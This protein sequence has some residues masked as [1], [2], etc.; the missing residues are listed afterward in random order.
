MDW[1]RREWRN[2]ADKTNIFQRLVSNRRRGRLK[3]LEREGRTKIEY[4]QK[5]SKS[6][7]QDR[8]K[9][10]FSKQARTYKGL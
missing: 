3:P 8:M 6:E 2:I 10:L 1:L 7:K 9:Y 4:H 5:D